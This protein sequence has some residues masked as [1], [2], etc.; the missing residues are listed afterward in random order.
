MYLVVDRMFQVEEEDIINLQPV[1]LHSPFLMVQIN[2]CGLDFTRGNDHEINEVRTMPKTPDHYIYKL[3]YLEQ[4]N[5][6][7]L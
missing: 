4:L 1:G 3:Y 7:D 5:K 2:G 6:H